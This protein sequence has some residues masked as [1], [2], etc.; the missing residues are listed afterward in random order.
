MTSER[1]PVV[2][3]SAP[4]ASPNA[5]ALPAPTQEPAGAER[6][7]GPLLRRRPCFRLWLG[8]CLVLFALCGCGGIEHFDGGGIPIG[9]GGASRLYGVVVDAENA[10]I[11]V[12]NAT[13]MVSP[14][15]PNNFKPLQAVTDS[16]GNF[17]FSNVSVPAATEQI[18][19][20]VMPLAGSGR[21]PQNL[22]F[23]LLQNQAADLVVSLPSDTFD[24]TKPAAVSVTT[25]LEVHKGD[26]VALQA[27]L[28]DAA[29]APLPALPSLLFD[30]N[31]G[32]IGSDGNFHSTADGT[33]SIV[34]LWD[35]AGRQLQADGQVVVNETAPQLPPPPPNL[36]SSGKK[37]TPR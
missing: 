23:S 29:G 9:G 37:A 1:T 15:T 22:T 21:L 25:S 32:T 4:I 14:V 31:I 36:V 13:I 10:F 3:D 16:N 12:P 5:S 26:S 30:G 18:R 27:R 28:L 17:N 2:S 19:V 11:P 8:L 35:A 24:Q 34:A 7:G 6:N 33:G 20:S